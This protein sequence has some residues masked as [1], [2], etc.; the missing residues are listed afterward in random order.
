M[1]PRHRGIVGS[2]GVAVVLN[3]SGLGTLFNQSLHM[4]M[5]E[6]SEAQLVLLS[7]GV[8]AHEA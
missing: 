6:E 2:C 4:L 5:S 1:A 7:E 3:N 8:T